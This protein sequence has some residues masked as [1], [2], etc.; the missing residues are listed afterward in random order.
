MKQRNLK[1]SSPLLRGARAHESCPPHLLLKASA[2]HIPL[3]DGSA[4]L[5]IAT[6]PHLGARPM[7][8]RE[9]CTSDPKEYA[10]ILADF[11]V[12]ATRVVRPEG[13]ILLFGA[14][15]EKGSG[16]SFEV[17]RM[18]K[19]D[20]KQPV[21]V[22]V[23]TEIIHAP[24]SSV[25]NFT[26]AALPVRLYDALIRRFSSP[27]ETVPHVFSGSGNS[28]IAA[29]ALGGT[30][31]LVDLHYHRL[32]RKRL[33]ALRFIRREKDSSRRALYSAYSQTPRVAFRRF[34]LP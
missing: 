4:H 21:A 31:I 15:R 28:A 8:E 14:R 20:G 6:P 3:L 5:V 26:W 1:H 23:R 16:K 17:L 25:K 18:Q 2:S 33:R 13:H 29:L 9:L 7:S 10:R 30:P 11:L 32:V 27:G 12:E 24:Y 22:R 34:L 19:I